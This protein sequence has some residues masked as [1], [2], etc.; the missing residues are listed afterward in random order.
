[1]ADDAVSRGLEAAQGLRTILIRQA[2]EAVREAKTAYDNDA[3]ERVHI[4]YP[5]LLA[6][7][8]KLRDLLRLD[9]PL[10]KKRKRV[11]F[12]QLPTSLQDLRAFSP[13]PYGR[14][15][16][17]VPEA[18]A[19][20]E[21]Q[22]EPRISGAYQ[23]VPS[24]QHLAYEDG[25][26]GVYYDLD[27]SDPNPQ[28]VAEALV[29]LSAGAPAPPPKPIPPFD[30]P[31]VEGSIAFDDINLLIGRGRGGALPRRRAR[32]FIGPQLPVYGPEL[33]VHGPELPV[34]GP[35]MTRGRYY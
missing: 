27:Y 1:M 13:P 23:P 20:G 16:S 31:V 25:V 32:R 7:R 2:E 33:P 6:A 21:P 22:S 9:D 18:A 4:L 3:G 17:Q 11:S 14:F 8:Q 35:T 24:P 30:T 28:F 12:D 34:Y 26:A 15:P 10:Y 19:M 29:Q 5:R